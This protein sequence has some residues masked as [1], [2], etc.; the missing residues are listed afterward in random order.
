MYPTFRYIL[1]AV[2]GYLIG[3]V[4][5]SIV[6]SRLLYHK[7]I[8]SQGSG[9]AG[10]TNAARVYGMGAGVLTLLGDFLKTLLALWLGRLLAGDWGLAAGGAAALIGHCYPVYFRFRGGKGV[11]SG[12]AVALMIDWRVFLAAVAVFLLAALLSK[13][14]SVA[15][16]SAALAVA[17]FSIVFAV[18]LSDLL[19]GLF[20]CV[21]VIVM[22]RS[23][24][25][26]LLHGEE[27]P[28]HAGK[29]PERNS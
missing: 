8:R 16:M 5:L 14:A 24:I 26:R 12:A 29:R 25:K 9:N 11:S 21:L 4:S 6:L 27:P 28:F 18:P 1:A 3:S 2:L 15:S 19:L 22:H 7:D 10:A 20:A 17:V 13:R 23:N